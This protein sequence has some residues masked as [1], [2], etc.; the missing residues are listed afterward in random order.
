MT[1]RGNVGKHIGS[2]DAGGP[3]CQTV[4]A[5]RRGRGPIFPGLAIGLLALLYSCGGNY[6]LDYYAVGYDAAGDI[7]APKFGADAVTKADAAGKADAST[8][9][10]GTEPDGSAED[11]EGEAANPDGV[12]AADGLTAGQDGAAGGGCGTAKACSE[13][14]ECPSL[15]CR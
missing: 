4:A 1:H 10:A 14:A 5:G 3:G 13:D 9:D 11:E 6:A 2:A 12:G 8:A 7:A 15:Q